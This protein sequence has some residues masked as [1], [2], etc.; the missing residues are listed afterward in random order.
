MPS[1]PERLVDYTVQ[2]KNARSGLHP[3]HGTCGPAALGEDSLCVE[4]GTAFL[5]ISLKLPRRAPNLLVCSLGLGIELRCGTIK[6]S[7]TRDDILVY[8]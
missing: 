6:R 8:R 2:S 3:V 1:N 7:A 4:N 5:R